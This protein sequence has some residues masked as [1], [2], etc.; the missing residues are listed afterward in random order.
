M[1]NELLEIA[2]EMRAAGEVEALARR[3]PVYGAPTQG[4]VCPQCAGSGR[5]SL[6]E[7]TA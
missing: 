6:D 1:K 4:E 2:D 7:V 5:R 3:C